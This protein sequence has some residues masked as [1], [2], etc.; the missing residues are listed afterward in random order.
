MKNL[1]SHQ[2]QTLRNWSVRSLAVA[3][4]VAIA[5]TMWCSSAFAQSGAGSIQGTVQD[6]THAVIPGA[7]VNVVNSATGVAVGTKSNGVGFYQVPGLFAG[8]YVVTV[9]TPGMET[10]K[11]TIELL[12]SQTFVANVALTPGAVTQQ[13]TVSANAVQ[14]VNTDNGTI[15]S[16][17]ENARINQLPM[18]GRNMNTLVTETTP[19]IDSGPESSA[20]ANGQ[21]G[22]AIEYEVDGTSLANLEWGGVYEG[23]FTTA[24]EVDPDAVQ[25]TQVED[26]GA[27]AQYDSPLTVVMA[28]KSGTN[29]LHGTMFYTARNNGFGIA[30]SRNNPSNYAAPKYVRNEFGISAGGP[31]V[32]PHV[33]HGKDK[34]FWFFAYERYSLAQDAVDSET[35]ATQ[36]MRN[37]DFSGLVNGSQ[38]FQQLY[39]P[40]TTNLTGSTSCPEPAS[41]GT[42]SYSQKW[43]RTPFNNNQIS[44]GLESP[45]AAILNK[46]M[47]L[48][49]NSND[50]LVA[51]NLSFPFPEI[52]TD[53]QASFRLDHEFNENNRAYLRYT[54]NKSN[55]I[56]PHLTDAA[57]SLAVPSA[58]LPARLTGESH[59]TAQTY[60][61]ALG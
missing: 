47:P 50:P 46:M 14:L 1:A 28:T 57:Y 26:L 31:I 33:Y 16:T 20:S 49:T 40:Y 37:G 11:R 45:T 25:E 56:G 2:T 9:T 60:A 19:G 8:T 36:A 51:S 34:S 41:A 3:A 27:G 24:H 53:P 59:S 21:M 18:N 17:L 35:V 55:S 52:V 23:N 4:G 6:P 44:P 30:R 15:T 54:Q 48:P 10:Y 22:A 42:A 61:G 39:N 29:Q 43:C 32:I 38:V 5:I 58:G 7:T 13:V 12:V